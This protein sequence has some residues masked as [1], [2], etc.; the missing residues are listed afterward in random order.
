MNKYNHLHHVT[1]KN[2]SFLTSNGC[3]LLPHL[4]SSRVLNCAIALRASSF[5]AHSCSSALSDSILL[6]TKAVLAASIGVQVHPLGHAAR[7]HGLVLK[8]LLGDGVPRS[9]AHHA[10]G[11]S[12][13]Q[14]ALLAAQQLLKLCPL[15]AAD[16][17]ARAE[18][19][20]PALAHLQ[21]R[22]ELLRH[23]DLVGLE[24]GGEGLV[25]GEAGETAAQ[26]VLQV[27]L[28][29]EQL[30][31]LLRE[32]L[33]LVCLCLLPVLLGVVQT[34]DARFDAVGGEGL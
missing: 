23:F 16:E 32:C 7:H 24:E 13:R 15:P 29:S 21:V 11:L 28:V 6:A 26:F 10:H 18:P 30:E 27:G 14:R 19:G 34:G 9:V 8:E 31:V 2:R 3:F 33:L 22:L 5:P 20:E 4:L 12:R 25:G 1:P 17:G